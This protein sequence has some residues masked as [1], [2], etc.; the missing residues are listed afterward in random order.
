[1]G[2]F[3]APM[4]SATVAIPAA[5]RWSDLHAC[6]VLPVRLNIVV[7]AADVDELEGRKREVEDQDAPAA[8][9]PIGEF[10]PN[11]ILSDPEAEANRSSPFTPNAPTLRPLTPLSSP[12]HWPPPAA[13]CPA[14]SGV[15]SNSPGEFVR[16]A[17]SPGVISLVHYARC[18]RV[19]RLRLL[20]AELFVQAVEMH[21]RRFCAVTADTESLFD[22]VGI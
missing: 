21:S 10:M 5:N 14:P 17:R 9:G 12:A 11:V 13:A 22:R 6:V 8:S 18:T 7:D 15:Q 3:V 2:T 16:R 4:G 1:M 20:S 19:R